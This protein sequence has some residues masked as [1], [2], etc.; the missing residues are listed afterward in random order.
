MGWEADSQR[1]RPLCVS[2]CVHCMCAYV[3][4][5]VCTHMCLCTCALLRVFV[6]M[7]S[8]V[9]IPACVVPVSM[10]LCVPVSLC[11]SVC[12][13]I[14]SSVQQERVLEAQACR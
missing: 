6:S 1:N 12:V 11:V 10:C 2:V 9:D 5:L 14:C 3:N 8:F 13:A 4:V 7:D